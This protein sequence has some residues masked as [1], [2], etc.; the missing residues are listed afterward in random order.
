MSD[1]K[2]ENAANRDATGSR[3]RFAYDSLLAAIL[4]GAMK[5]GER[6]R[7]TEVAEQLQISRTPVR[8][9]LRRLEAEGL[10]T[11]DANSRGLVIASLSY[12]EVM[13]LYQMREVLEGTAA[14]LA[15]RHASDAEIEVLRDLLEEEPDT[16]PDPALHAERNRQFHNALYHAA[17]NRYLLKSLNSL[18]D[19]LAL[20]GTTTFTIPGRPA[21]AHAEHARI[22][23]AIGER[24]PEAA[25]QHARE[26]IRAAQRARLKLLSLT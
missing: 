4:G 10:V 5:S 6:I 19:A 26:H 17:H 9:A 14:G 2:T 7:E 13:E 11:M 25:E 24:N 21:A 20:L 22:L 23:Q 8:E 16:A 1:K 18:R 3:A 12:Q 15:A